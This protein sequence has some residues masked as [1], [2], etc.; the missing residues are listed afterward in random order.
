MI[1]MIMITRCQYPLFKTKPL[2]VAVKKAQIASLNAIV[3]I[4]L[5]TKEFEAFSGVSVFGFDTQ[6][7]S[8]SDLRVFISVFESSVF[9]TEQRKAKTEK[10]YSVFINGAV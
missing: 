8:F 4:S 7:A 1:L 2:S 6:N 9:I 5:L 10:F 3:I